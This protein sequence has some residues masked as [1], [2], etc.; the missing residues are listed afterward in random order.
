MLQATK[1]QGHISF[2]GN[3]RQC[4]A[5]AF[6]A[7]RESYRTSP[8]NW[9]ID[10]LDTILN[11]GDKLYECIHEDMPT[12]INTYIMI[13][14]IP[15]Q[16]ENFYYLAQFSDPCSGSL[17]RQKTEIPFYSLQSALDKLCKQNN[18]R[19]IFTMGSSVPAYTSAIIH[20]DNQLYFFDPHSRNEAGMACPDGKATM[21]THNSTE[22]LCLFIKHLS[23]SLNG[24]NKNAD[25]SFELVGVSVQ[26]D[27]EPELEEDGFKGFS[28]DDDISDGELTCRLYT[29]IYDD[30]D[31]DPSPVSSPY[32]SSEESDNDINGTYGLKN[33][34]TLKID[35]I[36]GDNVGLAYDGDDDDDKD[37]DDDGCCEAGGKGVCNM[38]NG[39]DD[40]MD[41]DD[42]SKMNEFDNYPDSL[43]YD[44]NTGKFLNDSGN[45]VWLSASETSEGLP[46]HGSNN[47]GDV[48]IHYVE[49]N[50]GFDENDLSC[51]GV[52]VN[53]VSDVVIE[54]NDS[55][56]FSRDQ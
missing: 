50:E 9:K 30:S 6:A 48:V 32:M 8:K 33:E 21:T 16:M 4:M 34:E 46:Y 2:A 27:H 45:D 13:S 41:V 15:E 28:K 10:I 44:C 53:G 42:Y 14:D 23:S 55:H 40:N 17:K 3:G 39:I 43:T 35:D 38:E 19:C 26:P 36:D 29:L 11:T 12:D 20:L 47:A 56:S 49:I 37:D 25:P 51:A 52:V 22:A 7:I 18:T 24:T 31:C 5:N 1:H 54:E